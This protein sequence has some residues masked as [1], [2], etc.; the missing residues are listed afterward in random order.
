MTTCMKCGAEFPSFFR[1]RNGF[2]CQ[3]CFK[4]LPTVAKTKKKW[5]RDT[6][7]QDLMTTFSDMREPPFWRCGNIQ[8]TMNTLRAGDC[9]IEAGCLCEVGLQ[10][11]TTKFT[12]ASQIEGILLLELQTT[13]GY[14]IILPIYDQPIQLHYCR[15]PI[16]PEHIRS[17][18]TLVN[19]A[20]YQSCRNFKTVYDAFFAHHHRS[21]KQS[22]AH[23]TN[24][25]KSSAKNRAKP[26]QEFIQA[27]RLY[28]LQHPYSGEI[29][30][31]TRNELLKKYHPDVG[32]SSEICQQINQAYTILLKY[33]TG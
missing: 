7:Y 27:N 15:Q 23:Q 18:I 12:T 24:G 22:E 14:R 16:Y 21:Q 5:R 28:H 8:L 20:L 10:V 33:A 19:R 25:Q 6:Q 11:K 30:K 31:K 32:G 3:S 26:D 2:L 29:L 13:T 4:D 1:L 17:F 9:C